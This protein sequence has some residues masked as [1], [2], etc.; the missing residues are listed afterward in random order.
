[1]GARDTATV[2]D[3]RTYLSMCLIHSLTEDYQSAIHGTVNVLKQAIKAGV[4]KLVMTSS[5][6]ALVQPG[7]AWKVAPYVYTETGMKS[8]YPCS[9]ILNHDLLVDWADTTEEEAIQDG[10]PMFV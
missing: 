9:S 5:R 1:M 8:C 2:L 6:S 7:K 10:S 3:V 4:K